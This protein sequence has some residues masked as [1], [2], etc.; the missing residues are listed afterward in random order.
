MNSINITVNI[1]GLK[2]KIIFYLRFKEIL[3]FAELL[4]T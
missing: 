2:L 4:L 3:I 1:K